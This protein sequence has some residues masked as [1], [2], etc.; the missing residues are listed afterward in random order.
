MVEQ[1]VVTLHRHY[2]TL[3]RRC[4]LPISFPQWSIGIDDEPHADGYVR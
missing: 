1:L 2:N 3:E 4:F